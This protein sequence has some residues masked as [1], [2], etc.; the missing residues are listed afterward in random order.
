MSGELELAVRATSIGIGAT[1]VI[2]L[3]AQLSKRFW[4]IPLPNWGMVGRWF[5]HLL[6]GRFVHEDIAKASLVRG[7]VAIGWTAH[8]AIGIVYAT[9]L[10][11][12]KGPDWARH[13]TLLPALILWASNVSLSIFRDA[14]RH[15]RWSRS[16][17]NPQSEPSAPAQYSHS[18]GIWNWPIWLCLALSAA[19]PALMLR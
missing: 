7:E 14:A 8:Y 4:G 18:H 11:A 13:P 6:G 12:I 1:V 5:G 19:D 16:V 17:E 10:I 15:G 3:W 2:D 9:L